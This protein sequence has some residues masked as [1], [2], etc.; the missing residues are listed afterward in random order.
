MHS[1]TNITNPARAC[2]GSAGNW[3]AKQ[4]HNLHQLPAWTG[5]R[6]CRKAALTCHGLRVL[7]QM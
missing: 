2:L 1:C 5:S 4:H 3:K 7:K 6:V